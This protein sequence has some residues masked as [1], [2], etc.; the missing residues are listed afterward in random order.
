MTK[1]AHF[2]VIA[3]LASLGAATAFAQAPKKPVAGPIV[4]SLVGNPV[5]G[6]TLYQN[7]CTVCHSLDTNRIGPMHRGVVGR[8]VASVSGFTYSKPLKAQ[9]FI[10]TENNLDIWLTNPIAMVPGTSMFVRV[11]MAQDRADLIAYLKLQISPGSA[12][13][14]VAP[15]KKP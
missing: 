15:T 3:L 12:N 7:R 8:K 11:P 4:A 9:K 13:P 1:W 14:A 2:A 6:E 5:K 10:W